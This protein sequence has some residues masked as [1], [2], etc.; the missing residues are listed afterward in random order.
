[1][2]SS[3]HGNPGDRLV[4]ENDLQFKNLAEMTS[5]YE[6]RLR[7]DPN[8]AQA[9]G[10][11]GFIKN[12]LGKRAEAVEHLRRAI[13]LDPKD[14]EPHLH[15]GMIWLGQKQYAQAQSEFETALRLNP[16][17][18][19]AHGNLGLLHMRQ[20]RLRE[21]EMHLRAALGAFNANDIT[22]RRRISDAC[23]RR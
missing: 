10:R 17:A 22:S 14:D 20:G 11:L 6:H 4:L 19:L 2:D 18:Y 8:D 21:A 16:N 3:A 1:M 23:S 5:Y 15:L 12:A 9:H 7:L 13:E